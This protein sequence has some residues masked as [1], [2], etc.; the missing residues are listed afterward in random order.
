MEKETTNIAGAGNV[1]AHR[2][3]E[4]GEGE[5]EGGERERGGGR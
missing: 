2:E 3:R 5:R 1:E 4:V